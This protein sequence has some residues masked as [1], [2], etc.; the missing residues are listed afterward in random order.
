MADAPLIPLEFDSYARV[1]S[2]FVEEYQAQAYQFGIKLDFEPLI[3][4]ISEFNAHAELFHARLSQIDL[5]ASD[6]KAILS[7][8]NGKLI[9]MERKLLSEKGLPHRKW[10]KHVVFGP[11]FFEG[12]A[13]VAFPGLSVAFNDSDKLIQEHIFELAQ[14][15][16]NAA[17][18]LASP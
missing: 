7:K 17:D 10:Y 5:T 3:D 11:G 2:K 15:V 13:G 6:S 1:M 4:A 18:H 16:K 9:E 14:V 12:Y 8:W